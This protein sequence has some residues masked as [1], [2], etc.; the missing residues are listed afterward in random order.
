M[1]AL[2]KSLLVVVVVVL[3]YSVAKWVSSARLL[4]YVYEEYEYAVGG[5]GSKMAPNCAQ[6]QLESFMSVMQ[7]KWNRSPA[8]NCCSSG[9]GSKSV[10]SPMKSATFAGG[11]W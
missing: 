10:G 11:G 1:N 2:A 6:V 5:P 4:G 3:L 9:N 7:Q 8:R